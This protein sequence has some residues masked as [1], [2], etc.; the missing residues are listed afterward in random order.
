VVLVIFWRN[1]FG[2]SAVL[3]KLQTVANLQTYLLVG[4]FISHSNFLLIAETLQYAHGSYTKQTIN[5]ASKLDAAFHQHICETDVSASYSSRFKYTKDIRAFVAEYQPDRLFERQP[6][7]QHSS[8]PGFVR[9]LGIQQPDKLKERLINY[10]H[11][12][13]RYR[14]CLPN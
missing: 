7:R 14:A 6:G 5:R 1:F 8:F 4:Y 12:L 2:V 3:Y 13:D 11:K 9:R 10:S